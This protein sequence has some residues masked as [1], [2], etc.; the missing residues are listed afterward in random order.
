[1]VAAC[2]AGGGAERALLDTAALL[3]ERGHHVTVLTFES[4]TSDAYQVPACLSRAALGIPGQSGNRL[5]GI[6]NNL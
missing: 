3:S 1:M 6:L 5:R 4:Q 2:L